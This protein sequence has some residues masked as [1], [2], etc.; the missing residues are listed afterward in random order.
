[1][2]QCTLDDIALRDYPAAIREVRRVSAADSVQVIAHCVGSVTLLMS[3]AAG[4]ADGVRSAICSQ[5]SMHFDTT[6]MLR[7]KSALH[8]GS[9]LPRLGFN[10]LDA[11]YDSSAGWRDR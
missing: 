2:E 1:R 9:L 4:K 8:L 10:L 7:L 11:R 6:P 5:F 3:L